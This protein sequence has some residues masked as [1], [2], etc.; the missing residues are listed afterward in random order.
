[1]AFYPLGTV[2]SLRMSFLN[3]SFV[4]I[5][6]NV[7]SAQNFPALV[8]KSE[9]PTFRCQGVCPVGATKVQVE[10]VGTPVSGA[11]SISVAEVLVRDLTDLGI[12]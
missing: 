10:V 5:G 4:K 8:T 6:D 2:L 11:V 3:A 9:R 1:M 12:V 7:F